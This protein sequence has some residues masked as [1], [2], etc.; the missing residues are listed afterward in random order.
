MNATAFN[1]I[2]EIVLIKGCIIKASQEPVRSTKELDHLNRQICD[3]HER[4]KF[5]AGELKQS[6]QASIDIYNEIILN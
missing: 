6:I 2:D 3:M 1:L 5:L 4:M